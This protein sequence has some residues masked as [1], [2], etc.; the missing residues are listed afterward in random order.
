MKLSY[1]QHKHGGKIVEITAI[2]HSTYRR[3]AE[4]HFIGRCEWADG[5]HQRDP[6][7][8]YDI[9]PWALCWDPENRDADAEGRHVLNQL[10]NYLHDEGEYKFVG[11][12]ELWVP[13]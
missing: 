10:A 1:L 7:K 8:T 2:A 3:I 6:N 13:K 5:S 11:S 9:A 4:W 12:R